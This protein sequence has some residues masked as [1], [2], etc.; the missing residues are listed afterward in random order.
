MAKWI[1]ITDTENIPSLGSRV[2]H[3]VE[4]EIAV[5]KTRDVS[6]FARNNQ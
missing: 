3:Y 1:K 5:F 6:I 2:V 4:I